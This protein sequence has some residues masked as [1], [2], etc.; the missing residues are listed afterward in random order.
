M[1]YIHINQNLWDKRAAVHFDSEFYEQTNFLAG[2]NVLCEIVIPLLEKIPNFPNLSILHLQCH[3][4]M[5][6]LSLARMGAEV[7]GLDF[8]EKAIQQANFLCE[9]TGLKGRFVQANVFDAA[10]VLEGEQFD[11]I[12]TSYGTIGWLHDLNL[13]AEAWTPLLRKGGYFVFA[14]F[15]PALWMFD[16]DFTKIAYS[17]FN[18]ETIIEQTTGSYTDR[19]APVEAVSHSWNHPLQDVLT[20][21][22]KR[23]LKLLDFQEYDFSPYPCFNNTVKIAENRWQ[24][25]GLEDKIPMVYSL[26]LQK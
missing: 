3:F 1:D 5:D 10:K 19:N 9:K 24:I 4:G 11:M 16:D 17:Y 15:H 21:L 25:K 12:F 2:K 26:I 6:T 13:W 22:L 20:P 14:E 7:T 23:N 8:S 18:K